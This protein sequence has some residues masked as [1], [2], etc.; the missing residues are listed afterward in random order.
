MAKRERSANL[1][2]P[3]KEPV[4]L[5]KVI[6]HPTRL[7]ILESLL[8]GS[9][10]VKD[11]NCLVPMPQPSFS[12]HMAALRKAKLVGN[13]ADG[14]LRCYYI[15]RPSLVAGMIQ[16]LCEQHPIRYRDR[17]DVQREAK[18]LHRRRRNEKGKS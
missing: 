8:E 10:C 18:A 15:L 3:W 4:R 2:A 6:A 11:L 12:Q 14:T 13:H 7:V 5:L 16:T 1:E 9:R 17:E